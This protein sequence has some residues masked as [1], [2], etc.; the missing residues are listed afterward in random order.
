MLGFSLAFCDIA[1]SNSEVELKNIE[2]V[3]EQSSLF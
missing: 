3:E 1:I 2:L